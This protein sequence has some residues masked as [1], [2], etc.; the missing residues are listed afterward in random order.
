MPIVPDMSG[1]VV[2]LEEEVNSLKHQLAVAQQQQASSQQQLGQYQQAL[3]VL[4]GQLAQQAVAGIGGSVSAG[5]LE[6]TIGF[7]PTIDDMTDV[8]KFS[9][10]VIS[11]LQ[12]KDIKTARDNLMK[13]M[14]RL[15][16]HG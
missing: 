1:R 3:T 16:G 10:Y 14:S 2:E 9:K 11:A 7:H 15:N 6:P 12:F 8:Q 4:K 5:V 13:C